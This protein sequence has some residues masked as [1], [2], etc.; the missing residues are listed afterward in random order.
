MATVA[1]DHGVDEIASQPHQRAILPLQI[2]RD[3]RDLKSLLNFPYFAVATAITGVYPQNS[4]QASRE[5]DCAKYGPRYQ[6][7]F[8]LLDI[9]ARSSSHP[10]SPDHQGQKRVVVWPWKTR[11][12]IRAHPTDCQLSAPSLAD[13]GASASMLA[14]AP[15]GS[16]LRTRRQRQPKVGARLIAMARRHQQ[17]RP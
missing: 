14:R 10:H 13:P 3:G 5:D 4:S 9:H 16:P 15:S 8:E 6:H 1:V 11:A 17:P 2:Q 12:Q 7:G